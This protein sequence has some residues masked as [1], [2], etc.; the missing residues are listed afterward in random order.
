M[1]IEVNGK[2]STGVTAK[3]IILTVIGILGTAGGGGYALEFSGEG[4]K[5]SYH[6]RKNDGLQ[7]GN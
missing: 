6:G 3:D 1:K 4:Y 7:Y 5:K 2:L